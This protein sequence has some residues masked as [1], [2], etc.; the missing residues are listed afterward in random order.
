MEIKL[1][2]SYIKEEYTKIDGSFYTRDQSWNF[3]TPER[4]MEH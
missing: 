2:P 1:K 4:H 3:N